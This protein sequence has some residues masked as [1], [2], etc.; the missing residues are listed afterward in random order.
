MEVNKILLIARIEEL[1][2]E[3]GVNLNT[4][5]AESRVGKNFKSNL[6]TANPSEGKII[7][8]AEY[9]GV[10]VDYLVGK[11]DK[12]EKPADEGELTENVVIYHRDGKTVTKKFS[13]GQMEML[14]K[15]IDAIPEEEDG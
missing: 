14:A 9:F 6:S 13:K 2:K 10:S 5:F 4:A 8:L 11:T 12:K 15:M 7:M 1:A 3:K